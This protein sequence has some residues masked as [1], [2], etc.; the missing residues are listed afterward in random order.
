MTYPLRLTREEAE[1]GGRKRITLAR[2][3]QLADIVV[4]IP[5]GIRPGARLRL[6][7]K[8]RASPGARS[9]DVYLAVELRDDS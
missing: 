9:G 2:G 1:R 8:G 6:R 3:G 5:P 7:G 4:T